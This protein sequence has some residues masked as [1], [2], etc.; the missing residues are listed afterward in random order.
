MKHLKRA[1]DPPVQPGVSSPRSQGDEVFLV[2]Y[3]LLLTTVQ[4]S[5]AVEVVADATI[6]R[7]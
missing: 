3:E 6:F 4:G 7:F 5:V 1:F 2:L